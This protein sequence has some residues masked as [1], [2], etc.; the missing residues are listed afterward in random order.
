MGHKSHV[1]S[2][3]VGLVCTESVGVTVSTE[4]T[5]E[6]PKQRLLNITPRPLGL[7]QCYARTI[8]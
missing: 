2:L 4:S 8:S 7:T 3:M 5:L 1:F 6:K